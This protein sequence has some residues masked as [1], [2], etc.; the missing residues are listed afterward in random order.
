MI[1]NQRRQLLVASGG[2]LVTSLAASAAR[3][4]AAPAAP[5]AP[6]AAPTLGAAPKG[7]AAVPVTH[8]LARYAATA[9]ASQIPAAVRKE[10]A[11]T[12]LNWAGCA[13]GGSQQD[14]PTHAVAALKPFSGPAQAS[15]F[16]RRERLDAMQAALVNGISSHVLDY[17]DTHLKT[18]IHPAG[19]VA[20]ALAAFAEYH[21]VPGA[22]FM[23]ALVIGCEIECRMGNSVYPEHYAMGWHITGTTG[24]FGAA[25]AVGRLL[26]LDEQRMA[27]ALGNAASQPVGLKVQFGSD[28]KSFHPGK[29]AQNGMLSALL[30][31][32]GYT[33]SDVAIEGFDG[34]GQAMSTRHDWTEVTRGLG[35]RYEIGLNT[36]KPF[37][38]GIVAHPAI[39]A[40]IQLRA[41]H[42]IQPGQIAA[43]ELKAH[44]LTLNLMGKTE[45]RTGLEGKFSIYHATAVALVTGRGGDQAFRDAAVNDPAVVA[46]RKKV[47]VVVDPAIQPDQVDMTVTLTDGRKLH[48]FVEH[49]V[50]SQ[51]HPMSDAQL[52]EKFAGQAEGIL[53]PER[54]RRLMGVCWKAWELADAGDI[55]RA[56]AAA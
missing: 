11:R 20:S 8:I 47:V 33:A 25:A 12:L 52:E 29:A 44:A 39:D 42:A 16:G 54:T 35:E 31:Q 17:D 28:T 13:V 38:C 34:W 36:Y 26:K 6:V 5:S 45:P 15:L 50:G 40:A 37:A 51:L 18:I 22:D 56:A 23:N 30:A 14:A 7:P 3:A 32:Q 27:W 21:P 55:G 53:S 19:P 41:A 49:A 9:T 10:A 24:V 43:V 46:V 48:L 1:S 4:Q 2:A